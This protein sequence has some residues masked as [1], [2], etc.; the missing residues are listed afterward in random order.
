MSN[1]TRD[2]YHELLLVTR[3]ALNNDCLKK[4]P[5]GYKADNIRDI[6]VPNGRFNVTASGG[7]RSW[8]HKG[9]IVEMVD[10]NIVRV[11]D[12]AKCKCPMKHCRTCVNFM[13][14]P[15]DHDQ[16]AG[17][18]SLCATCDNGYK[19]VVV[20][21]YSD[22]YD[23]YWGNHCLKDCPPGYYVI[24]YDDLLTYYGANNPYLFIYGGNPKAQ[25][26]YP[27]NI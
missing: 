11:H 24:G 2:S 9:S 3:L 18:I 23:L 15:T 8:C 5:S 1:L 21:D 12:K 26:C 19:N 7:Y 14:L 25:W 6:C 27:T 4:C 10:G 13:Y 22:Q 20:Y 17:V 16:E